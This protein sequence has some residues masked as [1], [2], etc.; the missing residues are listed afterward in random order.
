MLT[1]A[2]QAVME[3]LCQGKSNKAIAIELDVSVN[4]VKT[5]VKHIFKKY[6][7]HSRTQLLVKNWKDSKQI[8]P[9]N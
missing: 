6:D 5:H 2:E 4:T 3:K 7:V 8:Y 1:P 9:D